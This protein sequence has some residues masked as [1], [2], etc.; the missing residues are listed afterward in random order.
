MAVA[1]ARKDLR[2]ALSILLEFDNR[3][4]AIAAKGHEPVLKQLRLAWWRE[5]LEKPESAPR[6]EP[7]LERIASAKEAGGLVSALQKLVEA[8]EHIIAADGDPQSPEL[9]SAVAFR[10][11]AVF[12]SYAVWRNS[13]ADMVH[14]AGKFWSRRSLGLRA[15]GAPALLPSA[16]KP[17][18]LLNLAHAISEDANIA[19]RLS[20]YLRMNWHALTG[21]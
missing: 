15:E 6:S 2:Q 19:A 9:E 18:N 16:L 7:L 11:E 8:W 20:K 4:M 3:L 5:Q 13:T 1:Y 12:G 14:T 21:M 10:S 17:L